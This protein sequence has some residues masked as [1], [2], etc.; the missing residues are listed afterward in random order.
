MKYAAST[1]APSCTSE[2]MT[3][4]TVAIEAHTPPLPA[5][6]SKAPA[7]TVGTTRMNIG[8]SPKHIEQ[9]FSFN[10]PHRTW[11]LKAEIAQ[12]WASL[13]RAPE[14]TVSLQDAPAALWGA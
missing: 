10:I 6:S 11:W 9:Q 14:A 4:I 12:L 1:P 3:S 5:R 2:Q 8:V 7:S 13:R